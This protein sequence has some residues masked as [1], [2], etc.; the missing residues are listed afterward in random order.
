MVL[1]VR[2]CSM[3]YLNHKSFQLNSCLFTHWLNSLMA[4][5]KFSK[6]ITRKQH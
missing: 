5:H 6:K 2:Y 3:Y 1:A 4:N